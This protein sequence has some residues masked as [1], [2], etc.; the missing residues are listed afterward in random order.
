MD[1][2]APPPR[3]DDNGL[4]ED[5]TGLEHADGTRE[6]YAALW[7][8]LRQ[9]DN[10]T[11]AAFS[12]DDAWSDLSERIDPAPA[13][14]R[15]ASDRSARQRAADAAPR[16]M[17]RWRAVASVAVLIA[18]AVGIGLWAAR[19]VAVETA[20][21]EQRTVTLP[22]GSVAELNGAT[23]ITYPRGFT[24]LPWIGHEARQVTLQGEAFFAVEPAARSFQ[25]DTD[26]A[27]IGV[28]GTAFN[29]R[30]RD[31][32]ERLV[33]EV[34]LASGQVQV[35]GLPESSSVHLDEAGLQSRVIGR[36]PPTPPEPV[37]VDQVAAW[38]QG[39]FSVRNAPLPDVLRDL[40]A[41]FGVPI[42]LGVPAAR[43]DSMTL[44]YRRVERLEAVL[45]DIALVQDM[46]YRKL[47]DGYEL[48]PLDDS[49]SESP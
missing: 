18:F 10:A 30:M 19:P 24:S 48:I 21:G 33:T 28:Y 14:D 15:R 1:T 17:R 23:T 39:G 42:R 40:E 31:P 27:R 20:R 7:Q 8:R 35:H 4:P 38:R 5:I 26:N 25:V 22:D 44:H 49:A 12:P 47:G 34:T 45:R 2:D 46:Q 37:E 13:S 41:Q 36:R 9:S 11:D 29:V 32:G 3:N 6:E 16:R 43:T